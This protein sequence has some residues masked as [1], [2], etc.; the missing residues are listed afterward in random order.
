VIFIADGSHA[1]Y[2]VRG[3][4][5]RTWPAP[6]DEADG[7]GEVARPR[8]VRIGGNRRRPWLRRS[9]R[10]GASRAG[11]FP[12]E[13]TSPRGPMDEPP[14][15]W[16]DPAAWAGAADDCMARRCDRRGECDLPETLVSAALA[17]LGLLGAMWLARRR[18]R[19]ADAR[20][21][22]PAAGPAAG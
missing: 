10:W 8:V 22:A 16:A 4:R 1:V 2:F 12:G 3:V 5:D 13:R 20:R 9:D 6:N 18:L 21:G 7:R 19:R 11:W 15:A 14:G 17:G